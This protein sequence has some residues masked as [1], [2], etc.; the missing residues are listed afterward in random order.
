MK[1]QKINILLAI[2][3][4]ILMIIAITIVIINP[5]KSAKTLENIP[6]IEEDTNYI[7]EKY[8]IHKEEKNISMQDGGVFCKIENQIVFYEEKNKTIYLYSINENKIN[9]IATIDNELNKMYFDGENIYYIPDYYSEKGIYKIDLKGNISKICEEASLQL[10]LT[11]NEIYFVKQIGYDDFN[12][13]PQGTIC[14]MDKDGNNIVDIVEN[15]KNN[16]FIENNKIYYTTQDR[17]MCMINKDGTNQINILQGRK[18][19]IDVTDKY[20]L[21]VDYSNQEAIHIIDFKTNEDIIISYYGELKICQGRTYLNARKRLDDGSIEINY[22]LFEIL[23][24]GTWKE[25]GKIQN[26]E[27]DIKYIL[28]GKV[29]MHNQQEG[30]YTLNLENNQK[31]NNEAYKQ[32]KYF[33]DGYGYKID[34]ANLEDIHIEIVQLS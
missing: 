21:Y 12:K 13:N 4:V 23:Y 17:K 24:D 28:N 2:I 10:M 34:D 22:T 19:I 27:S 30:I 32:C 9:K 16:F 3:L 29:Y 18:F 8:V 11:D 31:E 33:L 15:V 26:F 14:C 25:L 1:E 20:L 5:N 7:E 6:K